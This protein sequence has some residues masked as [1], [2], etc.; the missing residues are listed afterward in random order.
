M[1]LNADDFKNLTSSF[2]CISTSLQGW[3]KEKAGGARPPVKI[4]ASLVPL[5]EVYNKA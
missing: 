2:L 1:D 4:L 3:F 5:N